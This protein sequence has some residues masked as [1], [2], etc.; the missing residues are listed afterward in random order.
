MTDRQTPDVPPTQ[1]AEARGA[2][3]AYQDF[4]SGPATVVSIPPLAQN[5]EMAWEWPEIRTMLERSE[6]PIR[7]ICPGRVFRY[8]ND[9]RHSPMFHQVEGLVIEAPATLRVE[10]ARPLIIISSGNDATVAVAEHVAGSETVFAEPSMITRV[11]I[12]RTL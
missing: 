7:I 6:P 10:G 9:L 8:D 5:I 4:G 1:F 3:L 11:G 2:R 12:Q